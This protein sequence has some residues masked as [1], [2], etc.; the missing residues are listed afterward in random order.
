MPPRRAWAL[1]FSVSI[2]PDSK[3]YPI[4][5][6]E[7]RHPPSMTISGGALRKARSASHEQ[8]V[9]QQSAAGSSSM[10]HQQKPKHHDEVI[11]LMKE[12]Y[13]DAKILNLN[14]TTRTVQ[15]LLR[16]PQYRTEAGL[17]EQ[18]QRT[19]GSSLADLTKRLGGLYEQLEAVRWVRRAQTTPEAQET[20]EKLL[21]KVMNAEKRLWALECTKMDDGRGWILT[22]VRYFPKRLVCNQYRYPDQFC[23]L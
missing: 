20:R 14:C 16:D 4:A 17:V 7:A 19:R 3:R 23:Y 13:T 18:I 10:K 11:C 21:V 8:Q 5:K 15:N 22:E 9:S 6:R 2:Y 12:I 1:L